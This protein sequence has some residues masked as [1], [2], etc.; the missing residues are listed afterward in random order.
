MVFAKIGDCHVRGPKKIET[1]IAGATSIFG[2]RGKQL[3]LFKTDSWTLIYRSL[4]LKM[5]YAVIRAQAT[6]QY[7][8]LKLD[9]QNVY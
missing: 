4:N 5:L 3:S 9:N 1:V 2:I 8:S 7:L 6:S